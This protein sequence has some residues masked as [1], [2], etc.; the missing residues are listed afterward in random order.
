M[1]D[2]LVCNLGGTP[3]D[4]SNALV[5]IVSLIVTLIKIA[6]PIILVLFGMID[7]AKAVMSN[8]EKEMKGAQT[9]LIKRVVY[10]VLVFLVFSIVQ[11]LVGVLGNTSADTTD[12]SNNVAG[13]LACF[14]NKDC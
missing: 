7:L 5:Q 1:L 14:I 8:D 2:I 12:K 6:I 9:K 3:V 4:A 10:A 11:I 13:C